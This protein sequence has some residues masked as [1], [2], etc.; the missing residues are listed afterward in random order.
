MTCWCLKHYLYIFFLNVVHIFPVTKILATISTQ[1]LFSAYVCGYANR[2][3][4]KW[5]LEIELGTFHVNPHF[6]SCKRQPFILPSLFPAVDIRLD[7]QRT[8]REPPF[9]ASHI[10]IVAS[11]LQILLTMP[12]LHGFVGFKLGFWWWRRMCLSTAST[13]QLSSRRFW[14]SSYPM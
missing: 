8:S 10:A 7:V 3:A 2:M 13:L 14:L 6:P 4:R 9:F 11:R 1:I 12:T 5:R